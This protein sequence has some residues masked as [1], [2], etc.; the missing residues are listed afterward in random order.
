MG[1]SRDNLKERVHDKVRA[2]KKRENLKATTWQT[3]VAEQ[4]MVPLARQ[5][6]HFCFFS[7]SQNSV[8]KVLQLKV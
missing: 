3:C 4:M 7:F 1:S 6:R 5:K 2:L 8:L